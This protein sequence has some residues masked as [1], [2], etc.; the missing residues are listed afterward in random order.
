MD[1]TTSWKGPTIFKQ[2]NE[3]TKK[4]PPACLK[5]DVYVCCVGFLAI[6][7]K[8]KKEKK[9]RKQCVTCPLTRH[10]AIVVDVFLCH[11]WLIVMEAIQY[12]NLGSKKRLP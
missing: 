10:K 3:E 1:G 6:A 11:R 7:Q 12:L 4:Q 9:E 8:R 2:I 5:F